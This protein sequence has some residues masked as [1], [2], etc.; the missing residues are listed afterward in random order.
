MARL[1]VACIYVLTHLTLSLFS[2]H[3]YKLLKS[4]I[5]RVREEWSKRIKSSTALF[6]IAGIA[7][8]TDSFLHFF[9]A[10]A[11]LNHLGHAVLALPEK[12]SLVCAIVSTVCAVFGELLSLRIAKKGTMPYGSSNKS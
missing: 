3:V 6:V 11:I 12:A 10:Y 7:D 5:S 4:D 8:L 2:L 9:I 1:C